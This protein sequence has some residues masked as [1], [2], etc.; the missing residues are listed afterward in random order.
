[1]NFGPRQLHFIITFLL[2][3]FVVYF[4]AYF[5]AR[6]QNPWLHVDL[7]TIVIVYMA[8]EHFLFGAF[9]RLM[10]AGALMQ[11]LSGAPDGFFVMYFLLALVVANMISRRLVLHNMAS[12]FLSFAGIFVL[13]FV[14]LYFV[15]YK[16]GKQPSVWNFIE[17]SLPSLLATTACSVPLFAAFAWF[18]GLFEFASTR[19][20]KQEMIDS[21]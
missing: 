11:L 15:F 2:T 4:Q 5:I 14:L 20:R 21:F 18:D 13:K 17:L 19:E 1:M 12:Q 8:I 6:L 7:V 3:T 9:F 16:L 10:A